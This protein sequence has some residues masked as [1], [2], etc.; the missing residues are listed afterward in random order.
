MAP[1]RALWALPWQDY[2]LA[3]MTFSF[4]VQPLLMLA[5]GLFLIIRTTETKATYLFMGLLLAVGFHHWATFQFG[6]DFYIFIFAVSCFFLALKPRY[7]NPLLDTS[8]PALAGLALL[9]GFSAY[10]SKSILIYLLAFW[11][12]FRLF[13]SEL[14]LF[15]TTRSVWFYIS[16]VFAG[17]FLFIELYG[18]QIGPIRM[19]SGPNLDIAIGFFLLACFIKYFQHLRENGFYWKR[20]A[21][22]AISFA[23][24]IMPEWYFRAT[25]GPATT[26]NS[27]WTNDLIEF[28]KIITMLPA[29]FNEVF[30]SSD[31]S[32]FKYIATAF[33]VVAL[34]YCLS[35]WKEKRYWPFVLA[36]VLGIIAFLR[37]R[38]F[39]IGAPRYLFFATAAGIGCAGLWM[40]D[41]MSRGSPSWKKALVIVL[42][43]GTL[44]HQSLGRIQTVRYFSDRANCTYCVEAEEIIS[45]FEPLNVNTVI[46]DD[47]DYSNNLTL[48]TNK[49]TAFIVEGRDQ[50]LDLYERSLQEN[51][52]GFVFR[53]KQNSTTFLTQE[54]G[55]YIIQYLGSTGL[56]HLYLGQKT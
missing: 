51:R 18:R 13:F 41:W 3:Q 6:D 17:L 29:A 53:E 2:Q 35:K 16:A 7:E 40:N 37:V 5:A 15:A 32:F 38:T 43:I 56:H 26:S 10:T 36:I 22:F 55:A 52:V 24:G 49:K 14:K 4:I 23:I 50:P 48:L 47:Y 28:P 31:T 46:S 12:P 44:V 39:T 8:L 27:W 42:T 9:S 33:W 1:F 11:L 19:D 34:L 54:H 30:L 25:S 45:V 20:V 21:V